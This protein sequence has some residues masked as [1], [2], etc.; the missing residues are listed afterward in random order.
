MVDEIAKYAARF[1]YVTEIKFA[2][3]QDRLLDIEVQ[4][5]KIKDI[6]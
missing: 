1:F 6:A 5:S 3:S 4:E 2:V